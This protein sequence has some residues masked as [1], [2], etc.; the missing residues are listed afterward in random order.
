MFP[1]A[2]CLVALGMEAVVTKI[3]VSD[4]LARF[5]LLHLTALLF[6][7]VAVGMISLVVPTQVAV[8]QEP[9]LLVLLLVVAPL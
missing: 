3:V 7:L 2:L 6:L 8:V 4:A 5:V 1:A 9:A